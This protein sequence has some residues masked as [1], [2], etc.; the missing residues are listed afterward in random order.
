[1]TS[2][3]TAGLERYVPRL[4]MSRL[5]ADPSRR[6]E[7]LEGTFVF[8]DV[9][10]FTKLSERLAK[11]GKEGAEL[12]VDAINSCFTALL[13]DVHL[14]GGSLVK[15]GGDA[16]LLW[17]EG[18]AHAARGCEAAVGMRRRL[19]EVGRLTVGSGTVT[20]RMSVGVHSGEF[21]SFLVGDLFH[22]LVIGGSAASTVVALEGA[23][24]ASQILISEATAA[25]IPKRCVGEQ[26]G[27]G[28]CS[29]AR[30]GW[31]A[32]SNL[33]SCRG[34]ILR[35]TRF[36]YRPRSATRWKR[37]P[38]LQSTEPRPYRSS[39]LGA[40]TRCSSARAPK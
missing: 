17:F 3:T 32:S 30:P 26:T 15:F 7:V 2:L 4:L 35:C 11:V 25:Q 33:V 39:S 14:L 9:S 27:P 22:D 19:R 37:V 13:A 38:T 12:L 29:L 40:S 1:M 28:F 23:A 24:E 6:V 16:L 31:R 36:A 8:I 5:A 18:D 21:H 20:L 10:G 34:S